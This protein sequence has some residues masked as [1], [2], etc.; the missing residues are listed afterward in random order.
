MADE[1][2]R[3]SLDRLQKLR[4]EQSRAE[5]ET[6]AR[7]RELGDQHLKW[8]EETVE[9]YRREKEQRRLASS[10]TWEEETLAR[11]S[12]AIEQ[13]RKA[14][15]Q[16]GLWIEYRKSLERSL[17]LDRQ[18]RGIKGQGDKEIDPESLKKKSIREALFE[19]AVANNGLLI[20]TTATQILLDAGVSKDREHV[21]GLIYST[22]YH[23]K[24]YF[25]KERPGHY[26]V[27]TD[28]A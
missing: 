22:I 14:E 9:I 4:E 7:L 3:G 27:V 24:R 17:A 16:L 25:K 23:N 28:G 18:F 10:S 12:Y 6:L 1:R 21:R 2:N 20:A 19:I 26:R 5:E 8:D 15:K 11:L 13:Q